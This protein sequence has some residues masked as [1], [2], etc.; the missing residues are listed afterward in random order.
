MIAHQIFSECKRRHTPTSQPQSDCQNNKVQTVKSAM[1]LQ[2]QWIKTFFHEDTS[3][4]KK[5]IKP[6]TCIAILQYFAG[7]L[8]HGMR[9]H[10][11]EKALQMIMTIRN[12]GAKAIH[13]SLCCAIATWST[14]LKKS[15]IKLRCCFTLSGC[16]RRYQDA[17]FEIGVS[18]LETPVYRSKIFHHYTFFSP[19][20]RDAQG[21]LGM[22]WSC[23]NV[24]G[25]TSLGH[26]DM[27]TL[28]YAPRGAKAQS[29]KRNVRHAKYS[30]NECVLCKCQCGGC[31]LSMHMGASVV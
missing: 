6:R 14:L 16:S 24:L 13:G 17:L 21:M 8:Q 26:W 12:S 27:K 3:Y 1:R 9:V 20:H 23:S 7:G 10:L 19:T 28:L 30:I 5:N 2:T 29:A 18:N 4:T 15:M 11:T 22:R 31:P 25:L